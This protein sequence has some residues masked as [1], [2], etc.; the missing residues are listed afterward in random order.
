M[1]K[2]A[3]VEEDEDGEVAKGFG[4]IEVSGDLKRNGFGG[5]EG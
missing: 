3:E 4:K 5:M 2:T 1:W